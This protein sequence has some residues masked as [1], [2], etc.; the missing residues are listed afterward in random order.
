MIRLNKRKR[1]IALFFTI[2]TIG[3]VCLIVFGMMHFMRGE[4]HLSENYVDATVALLLAE[5]GVEESIFTIKSQMSE[6]DNA[7]Y[8]MITTQDSGTVEID[9][10]RLAKGE[11][12]VPAIMEGGDIKANV[13]WQVDNKSS[14]TSGGTSIPKDLLRE[15]W[16]CCRL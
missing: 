4:V 2:C 7:I 3:L 15:G 16:R 11:G 6:K 5:S 9:L 13:E 1:G 10:T 14:V 12:K 8:K